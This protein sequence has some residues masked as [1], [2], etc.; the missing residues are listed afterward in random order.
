MKQ[1]DLEWLAKLKACPACFGETSLVEERFDDGDIWY[2]PECFCCKLGLRENYP[3][4]K[5]AVEA[6]NSIDARPVV[7]ARWEH[8]ERVN[9]DGEI[10]DWFRCSECYDDAPIDRNGQ[11]YFSNHCPRCGSRM[12]RNSEEV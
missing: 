9:R 6:W 5:E 4:V 1:N 2:R 11:V 12:D 7:H 10:V 3:T 8:A